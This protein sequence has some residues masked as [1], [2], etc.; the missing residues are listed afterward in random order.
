MQSRH[1]LPVIHGR[2]NGGEGEEMNSEIIADRV[3]YF[4]AVLFG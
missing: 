4:F 1:R 3:G 2:A